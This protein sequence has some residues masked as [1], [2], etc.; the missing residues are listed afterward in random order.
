MSIRQWSEAALQTTLESIGDDVT[1]THPT[2][3]AEQILKA[4]VTRVDS[5]VDPQTGARVFAPHTAVTVRLSSLTFQPLDGWPVS[6]TDI[7][8][9]AITGVCRDL[10]FDYT[11]GTL[12]IMVE[13]SDA[14]D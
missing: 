6:T 11:L 14:N 8:G 1:F 7:S 4:Q 13:A 9:T 3:E 2:T 12:T 5:M 10:V